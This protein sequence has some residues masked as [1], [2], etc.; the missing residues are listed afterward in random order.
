MYQSV[1][2]SSLPVVRFLV[3][4]IAERLEPVALPIN[5]SPAGFGPYPS[6]DLL[7]SRYVVLES[8]PYSPSSQS[9]TRRAADQEGR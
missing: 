2:S 1:A 8:A 3:G 9:R 7:D 4:Q 5:L 6:D